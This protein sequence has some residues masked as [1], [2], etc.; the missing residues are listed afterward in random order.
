M[1][2]AQILLLTELLE[3]AEDFAY[4]HRDELLERAGLVWAELVSPANEP[5]RGTA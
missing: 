4:P 5:G 3:L 2:A 1:T